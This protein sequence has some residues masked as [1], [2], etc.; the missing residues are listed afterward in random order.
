[1][2]PHFDSAEFSAEDGSIWNRDRVLRLAWNLEVIGDQFR[3]QPVHIYSACR[4]KKQN[5]RLGGS[6]SS[7][8]LTGEAADFC[9][10]SVDA[11]LL[12]AVVHE[13]ARQ[14]RIDD[15]GIGLYRSYVH[16]D[17]RRCGSA[18]FGSHLVLAPEIS[19]RL[20]DGLSIQ[21][22]YASGQPILHTETENMD[23]TR[24]VVAGGAVAA[25]AT[26]AGLI[27]LALWLLNR[28]KSR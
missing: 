5:A 18:R 26:G 21:S 7:L 23:F 11:P 15:G 27:A 4:T 19:P 2:T 28:K 1:M 10:E 17:L 6:N 20:R 12:Y 14:G 9:V 22:I 24:A 13:L 8:H 25:G 16:Y 3:G